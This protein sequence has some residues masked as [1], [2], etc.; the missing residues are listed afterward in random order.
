MRLRRSSPAEP[1]WRRRR[2]GRG[3]EYL[4]AHGSRIADP[5]SLQ[6]IADLVIPPA[7]TDVWISPAV[8][9]HIQA[10]GTDAAGRRQYLYHAQWRTQ[11]D[12]AK[13]DRVLDLAARLPRA[14]VHTA[15]ALKGDDVTKSRALAAAF[16]ML[17]LGSFRIGS[18]SYADQHDTYG[19]ATI[20]REHVV[21]RGHSITFHYVAKGAKDREQRV[22]DSALA[23]VLAELIHRDDDDP[24]LLAWNDGNAWHDIHSADVNQHVHEMM[25]GDFTAKDF[26]TWNATVLM[27]QL[28][29]FE[30]SVT[31][32]T[33]RK[34]A[35][36][37]AYRGVADYLGNTVTVARSS[38]V[39]P[40]VVELFDDGVV[41]PRQSLPR[42]RRNLP[43]HGKV[44]R[45]VLR[46]L[47]SP[48]RSS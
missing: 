6:R 38:Y 40:R 36:V 27:A 25:R 47:R 28:L 15:N 23:K 45:A 19:L 26:R 30:G 46:M 32:T 3:F 48:Q 1:G 44:E 22:V 18:E 29:A 14:R 34:R 42:A 21:V 13:H 2:R 24:E 20:R 9:G 16:R 35:V 8:N 37:A 39:D 11:R 5:A 7:W 17:D 33:A 41:L 43:V 10:V 4:D 12:A 31:G